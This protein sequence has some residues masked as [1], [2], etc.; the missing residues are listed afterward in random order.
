MEEIG[1]DLGYHANA[2]K[3]WLIV[4]EEH[5]ARAAELFQGTDVQI[6]MEGQRHLGVAV[7][8]RAFV[9]T[10]VTGKVQE[11]VRKV[12]Q[13]AAIASS[14]PHPA[15]TAM[16]QGLLSKW[17]YLSRT[18]PNISDLFQPL[19]NAIRYKFLT[20]LTGRS[21]F[22][23]QERDLFALPTRLGGLGISNSTKSA[24]FM[25]DS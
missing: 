18:I 21:A 25:F 2:T 10:Y 24:N 8:S 5:A 14:Q 16:T 13:L 15:Y 17:S 7:G 23:N 20:T 9:E 6:T 11:S 19:E 4:K 3:S 1:P 12:E 22:T